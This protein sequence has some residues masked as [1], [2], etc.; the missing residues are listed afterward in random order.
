M[1]GRIR[2][3]WPAKAPTKW[4]IHEMVEAV[5]IV[6]WVTRATGLLKQMVPNAWLLLQR[7]HDGSIERGGQWYPVRP[8]VAGGLE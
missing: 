4:P 7:G 3:A 8:Y 1:A 5:C 6:K 2:R